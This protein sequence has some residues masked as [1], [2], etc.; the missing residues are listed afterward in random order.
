[1]VV[2][3]PGMG[4]DIQAIKAGIMEIGDVFVIN[5]SDREGVLRTEKEL[6]NLLTLAMRPDFWN[7]P[8]IKTIATEN[9]GI[10]DLSIA[11]TSYYDFQQKGETS[12]E[13]REQI[14]KWRLLEL[15][16]EKLLSDLM[17]KNGIAEKLDKLALEIA[18]K[19]TNPYSAVEEILK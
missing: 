3:V 11:I 7:S 1:V 14:A 2:L 10:E 12:L 8:I 15:I 17:R 16:R 6:E 5:K 13:R 9:K 4:D 18:E 19:K